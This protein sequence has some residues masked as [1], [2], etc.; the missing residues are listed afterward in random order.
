MVFFAIASHESSVASDV[1]DTPVLA[2]DSSLDG[3]AVLV[4]LSAHAAEDY[5]EAAG[6]RHEQS[7]VPLE[8]TQLLK[9][10]ILAK[11]N[12][13]THV[14]VDPDRFGQ[15]ARHPQN[16]IELSDPLLVHAELLKRLNSALSVPKLE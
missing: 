1:F 2:S 15:L 5:I 6:W 4:F 7:V 10:L 12:G 13:V 14:A 11:A 9:W 8:P 3:S 16:E